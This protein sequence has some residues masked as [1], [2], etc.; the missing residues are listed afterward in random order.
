MEHHE[1]NKSATYNSKKL[2]Y[3]NLHSQLEQLEKN[4]TR[5]QSNIKV[6]ADQVPSFRKMASVHSAMFMAASRVMNAPSDN[7][8]NP[9]QSAKKPHTS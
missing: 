3:A 6:T 5:L 7:V 1:S 9:G 8:N 4:I 2:H